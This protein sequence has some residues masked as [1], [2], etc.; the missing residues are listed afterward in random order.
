MGL[1]LGSA[2]CG[3]AIDDELSLLAHPR[4]PLVAKDRNGLIAALVALAESEGV[5][6]FVV[7]LPLSLRGE[8][9]R[10]ARRTESFA[11]ALAD[12]SGREVVLWDE[13]LTTVQAS[14]ALSEG[15]TDARGQRAVIDGAAAAFLL[16]SWL[17]ARRKRK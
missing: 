16:Q 13:R 10:A 7:G 11:Q 6:R 8:A 12:A 3:V 17:E 1:D 2:R 9:G 5:D 15:G 14:A 4:P